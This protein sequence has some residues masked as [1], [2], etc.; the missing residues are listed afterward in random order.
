MHAKS[1]RRYAHAGGKAKAAR[2]S[3]RSL[4]G[5]LSSLESAV[6]GLQWEASGT[7]WADYY[8]E[9]NYPPGAFEQ[10]KELVS[11]FLER[12]D[13]EVVWDLG[14]N[15]GVFSRLACDRRLRTVSL[16]FD[17]AAVER[18]YT[19]GKRRD[20]AYLVPVV[21]DLTNPSPG[22]GWDGRERDSLEERGP[23]DVLLALALVHH[24]AIGNNVPLLRVAEFFAR[25]GRWLVV[26][27]VPKEDSQVRRLLAPRE[28]VFRGYHASGF[29]AAFAERFAIVESAGIKGTERTLYL[30]RRKD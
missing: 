29:E 18:N 27:F 20:D 23:A 10:K 25:I 7:T 22:T 26:E 6:R 13:G 14:A 11:R 17:P 12:T 30:M 24:L 5:I 3:R 21:M 1:Q 2:V 28:D 19:E 9:T 4:E 15:T 8:E 16:D